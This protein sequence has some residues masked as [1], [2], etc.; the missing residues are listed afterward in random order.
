LIEQALSLAFFSWDNI[1]KMLFYF[2]QHKKLEKLKTAFGYLS[3][4]SSNFTVGSSR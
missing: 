2:G 1:A 4:Q 3:V